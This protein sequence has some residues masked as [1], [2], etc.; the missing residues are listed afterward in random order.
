AIEAVQN[1]DIRFIPERFSKQYLHW[2]ENIRDWCISRQLWWGHRIPVW[3]CQDCGEA[4]A[5]V[6]DPTHCT[7]CNSSNI[8]Q[9]P[10]VL[11]T[12]FSSALWPFSTMGWPEKTAELNHLYPTSVLVTGFDIIPFWVARMIF[13][14][15]EFMGQRPFKDVLIHGLVRDEHGRKMSKSLGNGIDP[16]EVIE[17]YGADALRFN[18]VIGVAPGNDLRFIPEKVEAYRNFANKI[19][20]AARFTLMNLENFEPGDQGLPE[21]LSVADQWIL[22]RFEYTAS[23]VTRLLERYDIGEGAKV[24][25]DFI[26][27]ELCDWYIEWIKPR[28]YGR[29]GEEERYTAQYVLW[30]VF[31]HTMELLHPYMPFITEE[32]W[33]K[34]PG[35]GNTIMYASWPTEQGLRNLDAEKTMELLMNVITEIRTIRSEKQVSPGRKIIAILQAEAEA[36]QILKDNSEYLKVLAGLESLEISLPGIKPERAVGAIANGVQIYLPLEGLVD[37]EEEIKR[38]EK[39]LNKAEEELAR[40]EQ[41]LAN[42][43]FVNKAPTAVVEKE[44]EKARLMADTVEKLRRLLQEATG[45]RV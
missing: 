25:Y 24:L 37:I 13:M 33:Q 15:L 10:D 28:L 17:Q 36:G 11:D 20:N 12:W 4:F 43:G 5:A 21:N 38:L 14:G 18:L 7:K 39:E 26:W 6:E 3:Y 44:R 1:G 2:M 22:S 29:Q 16:L 42:P 41:K 9:D 34:L 40:A 19:W 8:E 30:F 32:I 35:T 31:R 27:S 23:E 45:E